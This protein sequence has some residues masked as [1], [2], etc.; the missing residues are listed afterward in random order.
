MSE[1][2]SEYTV[3]TLAGFDPTCGIPLVKSEVHYFFMQGDGG[4]V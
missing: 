3:Y 4:G 2:T 1:N